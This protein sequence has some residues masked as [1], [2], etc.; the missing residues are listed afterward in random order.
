MI[1]TKLLLSMSIQWMLNS[2]TLS[3]I[4]SGSSWGCLMPW[5][6]LSEKT[7]LG[8]SFLGIFIR[9]SHEWTLF[10]SLP[11]AF[12]KDFNAP[13]AVIPPEI[14]FISPVGGLVSLIFR[15]WYWSSFHWYLYGSMFLTY[16][17]NFPYWIKVSTWS[18]KCLQ[19]LVRCP[20]S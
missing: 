14:V 13:F 18:F 12:F 7:T 4:T 3:M 19:S 20:W 5:L 2:S 17:C 16:F 1:S 11:C 8:L 6:S 9:G 10:I 15:V